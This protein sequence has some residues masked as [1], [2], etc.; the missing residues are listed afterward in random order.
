[1]AIG[2]LAL[3]LQARGRFR[4]AE[5]LQREAL[6][7]ATKVFG[8]DTLE[9]ALPLHN[10]AAVLAAQGI[11][12][13][14]KRSIAARLRSPGGSRPGILGVGSGL[15]NLATIFQQRGDYREARRYYLRAIALQESNFGPVHPEVFSPVRNLGNCLLEMGRPAE[16]APV[17]QRASTSLARGWANAIPTPAWRCSASAGWRPPAATSTRAATLLDSA[18]DVLG[19]APPPRFDRYVAETL[20]AQAKLALLRGDPMAAVTL[21]RQ[22]VALYEQLYPEGHLRLTRAQ[23]HLAEGLQAGRHPDEARA[24]LD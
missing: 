22:A 18:F 15:N 11:S 14:P 7:I 13:P 24:V 5:V 20:E 12:T 17:L 19:S 16:A 1:M 10:L 6:A 2:N 3:V 23:L 9:V 8:D 4:E 21:G